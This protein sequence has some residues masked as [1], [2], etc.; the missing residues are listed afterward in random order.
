MGAIPFVII[1]ASNWCSDEGPNCGGA[2]TAAT[3]YL[4][5]GIG[6]GMALDALIQK[7]TVVYRRPAVALDLT[8]RAGRGRAGVVLF[9]RF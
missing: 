2:S 8:P 7:S 5:G 3:L 4:A 1:E 6:A 9:V